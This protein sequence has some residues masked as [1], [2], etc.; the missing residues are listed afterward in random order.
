MVGLG[1][2]LIGLACGHVLI[3]QSCER[4]QPTA[5]GT[6]H[7]QMIQQGL[8]EKADRTQPRGASQ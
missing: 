3:V 1:G 2:Q 7:G 5:R 6:S 4:G 8:Y